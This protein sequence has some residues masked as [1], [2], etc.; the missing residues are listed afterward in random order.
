MSRWLFVFLCLGMG[1]GCQKNSTA[2]RSGE[3]IRAGAYAD[4]VQALAH[5]HNSK[6]MLV[7][8][9]SDGVC[10]EGGAD[11]WEHW[12]ADFQ[13][14]Q[15]L[16]LHTTTVGAQFD[17]SATR[18]LIGIGTI[19]SGWIDS[20]QALNI[21]ESHG[22]EAFRRNHPACDITASLSH[23]VIP[24][25]SP[26]WYVMYRDTIDVTGVLRVWVDAITGTV[27]SQ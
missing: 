1:L 11:R 3:M 14:D 5:H 13:T 19:S 26:V 9:R 20:D 10:P 18:K 16:Y 21:A 4:A 17:S 24:D 22:G 7:Q 8:I 2:P 23:P 12:Y 15:M 25:A 27:V 6:A